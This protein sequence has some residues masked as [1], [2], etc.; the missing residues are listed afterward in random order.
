M[1]PGDVAMLLSETSGLRVQTTSPG[2]G[3]ANI[4]IE[5]LRGRYTQ[6]LADGLP[7]HGGQTDGTGLLQIPP[8]D[9][10]QVEVLKGASSAL[11]GASALG[12]VIDFVSRRPDGVREALL[13]ETSRGGTDAAIWWAA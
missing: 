8:L 4:R 13:N 7:L 5:R 12:G 3:A 11:Y 9:L 2:L 10:R 6:V 1:S